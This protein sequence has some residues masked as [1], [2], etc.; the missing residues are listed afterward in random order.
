M[1]SMLSMETHSAA[2]TRIWAKLS[3]SKDGSWLPLYVH[4]HDTCCI[5]EKLWTQWISDSTKKT[6]CK[7]ILENSC[8]VESN[9]IVRFVAAAHDIGKCTPAFQMFIPRDKEFEALI[10]EKLSECGMTRKKISD[11]GMIK[12]SASSQYI[13]QQNGISPTISV[14][15]GGHH[16]ESPGNQLRKIAGYLKN[17]GRDDRDWIGLQNEFV[18]YAE[19]ISDLSH[20]DI[21]GISISCTGQALLSGIVIMADWIA[22]NSDLFPLGHK[23]SYDDEELR[24]RAE[25]AWDRLRL[26]GRWVPKP[27]RPQSYYGLRF[28]FEPRPLQSAALEIASAVEKT[29]IYIVEAPMGEGKTEAALAMSEAIASRFGQTGLFFALPTQATSDGIFL[30]LIEWL[31]KMDGEEPSQKTVYLSHG[32]SRYNNSFEE[33]PHLSSS[34]PEESIIRHD[35]MC[36]RKKGVLSDFV[37][38]T[39]DNVLMAGLKM[40]HLAMRHL[41]LCNKVIVIDE[42]HAYDEYMGSY[43]EKALQWFGAYG[44]PVI[45]LSATLPIDRKK[46]LL[47]SYLMGSGMKKGEM[48][49][50][51]GTGYPMITYTECGQVKEVGVSGT[52]MSMDVAV[53]IVSNENL[54]D[55]IDEMSAAGGYIGIIVNTVDKA[56]SIYRGLSDRYG[57]NEVRLLH[58]RFTAVDRSFNETEIREALG[59]KRERPPYRLFVIGTQVIE[60]SLDLDFDVLF[61]ELCPMDFL[62]QRMG[63]LHRHRNPRPPGL[64]RPI[65]YVIDSDELDAGSASI[66]GRYHLYNTRILL[67]DSICIPGDISPLVQQ[68]YGNPLAV[69]EDLRTDYEAAYKEELAKIQNKTQKA[70]T[71]QI[72]GPETTEN[73][74]RIIR[75]W[76]KDDF[77]MK[78][79][80]EAKSAVRDIE[81]S[82]EAILVRKDPE[83]RFHMV[84][85]HLDQDK[86][87]GEDI[88]QQEAFDLSGCR[89]SLPR[90]FS[91]GDLEPF[92]EEIPQSWRSSPWLHDELF[93]V[94]HE[95][96]GDTLKHADYLHTVGLIKTMEATKADGRKRIQS[97]R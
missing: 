73:S 1:N 37:A 69:P 78:G 14:I 85:K 11:P 66:Y 56:Q 32:K 42:V 4:M 21:A 28:G 3:Y 31:R 74:D 27:V 68:A 76:T 5:A 53:R 40:R 81:E 60:Q 13:L 25:T 17:I 93:L 88:T 26:P 20:E 94:L 2:F 70:K 48:D 44:V 65:C 52:K 43:M 47:S 95:N 82:V 87:I 62:L 72:K 90:D 97:D 12:H 71:F 39:V 64:E 30:R 7:S 79:Q 29:G 86:A 80:V 54:M 96:P 67:P 89:I 24:N 59:P 19:S 38:G 75:D 55:R 8:S 92:L 36:G 23:D 9:R 15:S 41:G 49:L 77:D 22:S 57:E 51:L 35:W 50:R 6:I 61:T 16:G 46:K 63:R 10:T 45:M 33:I 84:S 58:S 18:G 34:D 91:Y 83:G